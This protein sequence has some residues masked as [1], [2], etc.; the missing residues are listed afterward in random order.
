MTTPPE[1]RND[2][3]ITPCWEVRGGRSCNKGHGGL[4]LYFKLF[5]PPLASYM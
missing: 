3:G 4:P 5:N 1:G 2:V